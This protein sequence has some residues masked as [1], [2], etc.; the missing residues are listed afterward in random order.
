MSKLHG[1]PLPPIPPSQSKKKPKQSKGKSSG[2][3]KPKSESSLLK[4]TFQ[5]I[6]KNAPDMLSTLSDVFYPGSGAIVRKVS[7]G[8]L[9]AFAKLTGWGDYEIQENSI[10]AHP[11]VTAPVPVFGHGGMRI[12]DQEYVGVLKVHSDGS[13]HGVADFFLNPRNQRLF[14]K[15]SVIASQY[16]QFCIHG[17]VIRFESLCSESVSNT[18]SNMSIPT[19]IVMTQY[20][21][22]GATPTNDREMLNAFFAN[23]SRINKDFLHPIE[24]SP[25]TRPAEV[26]YC[27]RVAHNS[28]IRDQNLSNLGRVWIASQ[29]GNHTTAFGAYRMY[30]EYDIELIKARP[31]L[32]AQIDDVFAGS[33]PATGKPLGSTITMETSS[34]DYGVP[35]GDLIYSIKDNVLTF[36]PLFTGDI[37]LTW[38]AY[39]SVATSNT[40]AFTLGTGITAKNI[41][42]S[43]TQPGYGNY[44]ETTTM[45]FLTKAISVAG[46]G[47]VTLADVTS[48][49]FAMSQF[50]IETL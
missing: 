18:T 26:L 16:Q 8:A 20:D 7:K 13:F 15:L 25:S 44:G 14:P 34:S 12:K 9:G 10:I 38:Y 50:M 23:S 17:M 49:N 6:N 39:Y 30:V 22:N 3:G 41:F 37:Q 43:G 31:I 40:M 21:V 36:D 2:K 11:N 27:D 47:T 29:G 45:W 32:Q 19:F 5:S 4:S 1:K 46:G 33:A 24:C 35:S 28:S 42:Q 48:S